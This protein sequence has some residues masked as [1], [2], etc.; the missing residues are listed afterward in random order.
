LD[1]LL[2]AD[3]W[4]REMVQSQVVSRAGASALTH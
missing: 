3:R 4:A 1:D 2:E